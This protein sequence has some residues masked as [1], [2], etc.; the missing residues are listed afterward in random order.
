MQ[1]L[2]WVFLIFQIS[3]TEGQ[4]PDYIPDNGLQAWYSFSGNSNDGTSFGNHA[5][6]QNATLAT[7]RFNNPNSAYQFNGIDSYIFSNL[8]I[9]G[10]YSISLWF[11]CDSILHEFN[12]LFSYNSGYAELTHDSLAYARFQNPTPPSIGCLSTFKLFP[13]QW[14]QLLYI[15][16]NTA[17]TLKVII[18]NE[19]PITFTLTN[20]GTYNIN[21]LNNKFYFG[22]YALAST[23]YFKGRIDDIAI[24]NRILEQDEIREITNTLPNNVGVGILNPQ[25]KLHVRDV[26]RL[27]PRNSPPDQPSKGDIYF[28][29]YL[30][31]LRVFDGTN[32]QNCW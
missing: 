3:S 23:N 6:V 18:D 17:N 20:D 4:V 7:D 24:W 25:R 32:W 2:L 5:I 21:W 28:D 29:G 27:E 31:K 11:Y 22:A 30:N 16:S 13:K 8:N 15:Y 9:P 26:L 19:S 1:K 12:N 14:H 10:N